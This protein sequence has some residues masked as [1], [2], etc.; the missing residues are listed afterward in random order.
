MKY[1][2]NF[3]LSCVWSQMK[4]TQFKWL[5]KYKATYAMS[6]LPPLHKQLVL[7][8]KMGDHLGE[9]LTHR[10]VS[11]EPGKFNNCCITLH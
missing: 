4:L 5:S 3:R 10:P 7:V 11:S 6:Q 1:T 8:D 9:E 2:D